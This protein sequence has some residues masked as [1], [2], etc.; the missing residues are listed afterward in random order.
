MRKRT[1]LL[2]LIVIFAVE[3]TALLLFMFQNADILQD[4]VQVNEIVHLVQS[5]WNKM[6]NHR[7]LTE[8]EY[9]V[10]DRMGEVVFRSR[11]GLSESINEAVIHRDTMMDIYEGDLSVGR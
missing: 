9:V 11:E 1:I 4:A 7:N 10:L 5:D 2:S 6:E 3:I 8:L